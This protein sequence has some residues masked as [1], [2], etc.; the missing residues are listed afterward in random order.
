MLTPDAASQE[1]SASAEVQPEDQGAQARPARRHA[2]KSNV[3]LPSEV[4]VRI[5]LRT[6]GPANPFGEPESKRQVED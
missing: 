3:G 2:T 5:L 4:A 1:E 6:S